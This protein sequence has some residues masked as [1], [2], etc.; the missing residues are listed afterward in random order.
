MCKSSKRP[1]TCKPSAQTAKGTE[2][3]DI[4][5]FSLQPSE[6]EESKSIP[7]K[8]SGLWHF[9]SVGLTVHTVTRGLEDR[10]LSQLSRTRKDR[11]DGSTNTRYRKSPIQ[12]DR[13]GRVEPKARGVGNEHVSNK[14]LQMRKSKDY[15]HNRYWTVSNSTEQSGKFRKIYRER[16]RVTYGNT[17]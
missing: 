4:L 16:E 17:R 1:A 13:R 14:C 6:G 5:I 9:V 11:L 12:W 7:L 2:P 10:L 15:F 3:R 8:P